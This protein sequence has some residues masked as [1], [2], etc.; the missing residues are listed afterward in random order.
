MPSQK[1]SH[2]QSLLDV[3]SDAAGLLD[4]DADSDVDGD[5]AL[6]AITNVTNPG[7][8]DHGYSKADLGDSNSSFGRLRVLELRW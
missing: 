6:L 7:F 8:G 3:V 5:E 1:A 4:S 2:V